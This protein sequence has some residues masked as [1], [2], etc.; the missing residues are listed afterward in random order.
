MCRKGPRDWTYFFILSVLSFGEII[1]WLHHTL[2]LLSYSQHSVFTA[3]VLQAE[4]K[5][6]ESD[7]QAPT[8][9]RLID[10]SH[11]CLW[12]FSGAVILRGSGLLHACAGHSGKGTVSMAP[13]WV[14]SSTFEY[15]WRWLPENHQQRIWMKRLIQFLLSWVRIFSFNNT[16][17]I[18][19]FVGRITVKGNS[20]FLWLKRCF[21]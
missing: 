7:K 21:Q 5:I 3:N 2:A 6:Q 1:P 11:L 14:E 16:V 13:S 20:G 12:R 19:Y 4:A 9:S 15:L 18:L 17:Q 8:W 10:S